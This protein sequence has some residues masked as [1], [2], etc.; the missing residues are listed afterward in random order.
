MLV[1]ITDAGR[2]EVRE[3]RRRRTAWLAG[4]LAELTP[5]ERDTLARA[6]DI[7]RRVVATV[8]PTFASLKVFNYRVYATGAIVSNA[9]TWMQRVAQ[10]WLVL[11]VLTDHSAVA[12]GITTGLQF[13]PML[14]LAPVGG[15]I[16]D[17]FPK[18][19]WMMTTQAVAGSLSLLLGLM[20]ILDV[21]ALWH[22]YVIAFLSGSG[23]GARGAGTADVRG[24]DG[25]GGPALERGRAEQRLVPPRAAHRSC[26]RRPADRRVRHRPRLPDQRRQLRR[27]H[28]RAVADA[29]ARAAAGGQGPAGQGAD[30][31]RHPR[32]CADGPTS[33]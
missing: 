27:D 30:P 5:D 10:D 28:L 11:T 24:R 3:T 4:R 19:T 15:L 32:T 14:L 7:L 13:L 16:A 25:A 9:G 12:V 20:V 17:R 2:A 26:A 23:G 29:G 8:S 31:R 33:W 21:A 18:R 1:D 22:V 6:A